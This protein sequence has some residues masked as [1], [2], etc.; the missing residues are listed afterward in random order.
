M[1]GDQDRRN[2]DNDEDDNGDFENGGT[3]YSELTGFQRDLLHI[4]AG[5]DEPHGLK[6]KNKLEQYYGTEVHHGRLYPNLDTLTEI[7][8]LEKGEV[9]R[10]TNYYILTQHG[11]RALETRREWEVRMSSSSA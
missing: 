11:R 9:D 4:I 3:L 7:G 10:R 6:I 1:S 8:V 5:L 2:Q